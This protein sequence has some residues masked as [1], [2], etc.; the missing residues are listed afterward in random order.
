MIESKD[1]PSASQTDRRLEFPLKAS[2]PNKLFA[3]YTSL[4]DLN[5]VEL[6]KK[7]NK[8]VSKRVK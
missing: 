7:I 8:Y 6:Q 5:A 4:V 3:L 1:N 2:D